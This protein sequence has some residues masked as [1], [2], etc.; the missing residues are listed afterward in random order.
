V[1]HFSVK[2]RE[3]SE[4]YLCPSACCGCVWLSLKIDG[5]LHLYYSNAQSV[6]RTLAHRTRCERKPDDR[7]DVTDTKTTPAREP[8]EAQNSKPSL[9]LRKRETACMHG[10][11]ISRL[12][13]AP[14]LAISPAWR[15]H[16]ENVMRPLLCTPLPTPRT[17]RP[18]KD[19]RLHPL[20]M[21]CRVPH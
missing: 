7:S 19:T 20:L 2:S 13:H 3:D 4:R 8:R 12:K 18:C 17:L 16:G 21:S 6:S 1:L 10:D 11:P 15:L 14:C 9:D 5:S